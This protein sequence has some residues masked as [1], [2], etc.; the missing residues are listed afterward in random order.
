MPLT[1]LVV[2]DDLGT[3]LSIS[4][5]LE[6]SGY[7]VIAA[8]NGRD[9]LR[10]FEAH[11]PHL[12]VTDIAMPEMDGYELVRNVRSRP[13]FCLLPVIFL[14]AHTA[15]K[16]RVRGYQSGCDNYLSKPFELEEL[17]VVIRSLL[18]R[19]QLI[20]AEMQSRLS[21]TQTSSDSGSLSRLSTVFPPIQIDLTEREQ[22]VLTLL[23]EGCSNGQIG[24][25]LHLSPRTIEKYVSS[26][27]RKT[28]SN[29]RAELVRF[30]LQNQLAG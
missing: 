22:Q 4:D 1:I 26:L 23:I 8:K 15:T 28:E 5:Y 13:E 16:D 30:A 19:S 9:A 18:N 29:N 10:Y 24:N 2:D 20:E 6:L 14:T 3:R 17:S 7:L 21:E 12:I 27:L 25:H 11:K